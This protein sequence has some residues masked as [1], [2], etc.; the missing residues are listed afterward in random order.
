MRYEEGGGS[1]NK[2]TVKRGEDY[3]SIAK[4]VYGNDA[5]SGALARANKKRRLRAGM[6]INLPPPPAGMVQAV[7]SSFYDEMG[8]PATT[9]R[10]NK[11]ARNRK[12]PYRGSFRGEEGFRDYYFP[13]REGNFTKPYQTGYVS[14]NNP[15]FAERA[16]AGVQ[17]YGDEAAQ[18][19]GPHGVLSPA[20]NAYGFRFQTND[21]PAAAPGYVPPQGQYPGHGAV[22]PQPGGKVRP[23]LRPNPFAGVTA[24]AVAARSP[25]PPNPFTGQGMLPEEITNPF[26]G[27]QAGAVANSDLMSAFRFQTNGSLGG[28]FAGARAGAVSG[29]MPTTRAPAPAWATPDYLYRSAQRNL[30]IPPSPYAWNGTMLPDTDA[31]SFPRTANSIEAQLQAGIMPS[32]ISLRD[33]DYNGYSAQD[34]LAAGYV[35]DGYGWRHYS[36]VGEV[37]AGGA[38]GGKGRGSGGRSGGGRGG[39]RRAKGGGGDTGPTG[40]GGG[41]GGISGG[42]QMDEGA[43]LGLINWRV[44]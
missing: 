7:P 28:P 39:G 41:W 18:P 38:G 17:S 13:D 10:P 26:T 11:L 12:G 9:A 3:L 35:R 23:A 19:A 29:A 15:L 8:Q 2:R 33:A 4:N 21:T 42:R 24:G 27:V 14:R 1:R 5:Y 22:T 43:V 20:T 30:K 16:A 36:T 40:G 32:R 34:L 44:G 31:Q 6:V 37:G 25:I